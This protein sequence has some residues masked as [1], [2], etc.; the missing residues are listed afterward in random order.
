MTNVRVRGDWI[1]WTPVL[2]DDRQLVELPEDF[3]LRELMQLDPHDL[4]GAAEMMRTYG[5]L[6]SM[7]HDD[8][9]VDSE[10][11]YEELQTIPEA[12]GDDQPHPF[13]IHRDLVRIHLQTAQEAITTWLACR[14]AGGLE[15]LVKPH[16]TPE[17]LAGVQAQNPDHDPPWPPSLEYL[18][19][20][21]IDS[22]IS[23]LQHVLNAALSRFSIGIGNL[24]DRSPTIVSVAFLQLY[25]HLVEGATVRHCANEP[26]GRAFVRQ[27][28]RAEYGQHRTTGIKYCTRE[29]ARAQAQRALRRRRKP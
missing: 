29:C 18:E 6:S 14:R 22:Q 16:I 1:L 25:N 2:W 11:V 19:A 5:T 20:L 9:Y 3:Y 26:C 27:R 12:G 13:G 23:S 10:D 21:L 4:E 28:G 17:N 24:S 8:L 15:E 7:D